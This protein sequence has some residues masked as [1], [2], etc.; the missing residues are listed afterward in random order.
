MTL[1]PIPTDR[2]CT[3]SLPTTLYRTSEITQQPIS[4]LWPCIISTAA[5]SGGTP[6]HSTSSCA[7]STSLSPPH[8][9]SNPRLCGSSSGTS[10]R[11]RRTSFTA[12]TV[13]CS[14]SPRISTSSAMRTVPRL[15][16][17]P[18]SRPAP[19]SSQPSLPLLPYAQSWL[20]SPPRCH[21]CR[22]PSP[23]TPHHSAYTHAPS[24]QN[25]PL[26]EPVKQ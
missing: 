26:L 14:P 19:A 10:T 20:L 5:T 11:T 15:T 13:S 6:D 18:S 3:N 2:P 8:L 17:L 23:A 21:H 9:P 25:K 7:C 24:P 16:P 12:P 1:G 4:A 22:P